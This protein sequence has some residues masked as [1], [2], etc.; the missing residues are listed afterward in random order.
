MKIFVTGGAGFIGSAFIRYLLSNYDNKILNYDK[1]SYA[2]NLN[3]LASI[4]NNK[5]YSFIKGD[6]CN[7]S[8]LSKS[9]I[10]FKP[11]LVVHFAAETHVD[12]SINNPEEFINT[13]IIGTYNLLD[14]CLKYWNKNFVKE[15]T[16]RFHH[17]STDEVYGDL[18]K[19]EFFSEYTPYDPSSPYSA[20]KAS[21]DHLVR[22][23]FRTFGLPITITNC[24]N[25]YG[26]YQ[27]PEK[28]IPL[29]IL[30]AIENK[31]LPIY[32]D[33]SQIRDWLHVDDHIEALIK[34]TK[35]GKSGEQYCIGA[36]NEITNLQIA[37]K[38]CSIMDDLKPRDFKYCELIKFV[39]DRPG[40][41]ERYSIEPQKIMSEVSWSPQIDF[42]FGLRETISWYINNLDWCTK[43]LKKF[44]Y[45]G[46][47][48][49]L[50]K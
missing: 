9:I 7:K 33:G 42:D 25:N 43:E 26:P 41:D 44:N 45:S 10:N 18:K 3:S 40:H 17:I 8:H 39:E 32:G 30:N 35:K 21:S 16:F 22:S 6:I 27:Y 28:L 5:N 38:I 19:N 2:G 47:R 31:P 49:G 14:E 50:I 20:S 4:S 29:M 23:W 24:S 34:L 36:M 11:D 48:L 46:E 12:R 37:E 1:L 15:N 13:N